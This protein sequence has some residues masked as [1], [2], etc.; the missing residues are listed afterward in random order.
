MKLIYCKECGDIVRLRGELRGC[1]CGG[2]TGRYIGVFQAEIGGSAIP[3][4]FDS[5][6]FFVAIEER[7][8][9]GLGKGFTAFVIPEECETVEEVD[10]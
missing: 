1:W 6:D 5:L 8:E 4:G 3:L 9:K 2:S 7:P 10:K